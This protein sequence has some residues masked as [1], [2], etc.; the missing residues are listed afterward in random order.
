MTDWSKLQDIEDALKVATLPKEPINLNSSTRVIDHIKF[1]STH[2]SVCKQNFGKS[3]FLP[4]LQ[5][6][7]QY[8][9]IITNN[10]NKES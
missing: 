2:L 1:A 6:L 7:N 10:G 9:K 4:Y 5:R 3:T 8:T